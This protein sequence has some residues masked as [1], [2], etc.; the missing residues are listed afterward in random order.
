MPRN[1]VCDLDFEIIDNYVLKN[2]EISKK[3]ISFPDD[4]VP[5]QGSPFLKN[6][7]TMKDILKDFSR[8]YS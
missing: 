7:S 5:T 2:K 4:A 1:N 3:H 6:A 8:L